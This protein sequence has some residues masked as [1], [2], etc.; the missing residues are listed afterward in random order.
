MA[1]RRGR[2]RRSAEPGPGRLWR[3]GWVLP[4]ASAAIRD[5]AVAVRD[6]LIADVG[7]VELV[8][9]RHPDLER[10]DLG[11][12]ILMPGL[13]DAHCH[14][15]WSLLDGLLEPDGFGPWL[16]RMLPLRA[17]LTPDDH[18]AAARF[19]ALRA[20]TA[21]T[22]TL[23]D[24]GPTGAGAAAL[25]ESGQRG[26]VHLEAFGR[27]EGDAAR[28][29]ADA[30]AEQVA[31]LDPAVGGRGRIGVSPH[32]P[33][34][35]GPAFWT[36]LRAHP[37]LAARPWATHLAE[38]SE[39]EEVVSSGGGA[40]GR[41][42]ADGGFALGRWDGP[43]GS[44]VVPRV[45]AAG[46]L[47][48]G[49]VAAHCVRL[50]PRDAAMLAAAGVG[51]AHCPRSNAYLR[52]GRAPLE[53]LEA[54]GVAVGLGTDSPASG[55]DYDLRAEAR[56]CRDLHAG[57]RELSPPELLRLVTLGAAETLG[58]E[59]EV[60]AIAPGRRAD[61]IAVSPP[62]APGDAPEAWALDARAAVDLVVVDGEVL[63]RDGSPQRLDAE[64]IHRAAAEAR[65]RLC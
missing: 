9:S 2:T 46:A 18:V 63:L 14:L 16:G 47:A 45:A 29:A 34:T 19:G 61:L 3:A 57:V 37:G 52:C 62:R 32:A 28:A 35:V 64:P 7:P 39:E 15:E 50:G 24:S 53:R 58:M 40:I 56:A 20:L 55:G 60:G 10:E 26:L 4:V 13:I 1:P 49:L 22:T 31:A 12:R 41:V 25:A 65:A 54:A 48:T 42:F 5:G 23:A 59:R 33:Y 11:P 44:G 27:E 8:A 43:D 30:V 51:V 38:S 21:G 36:A 17:R 6:G